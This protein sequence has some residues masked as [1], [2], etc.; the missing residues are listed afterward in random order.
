[1]AV[2]V[3]AAAADD[4]GG[5][6]QRP[7]SNAERKAKRAEAQRLGRRL[8]S[9]NLGQKGL[10]PAFLEGFR[11]ALAA[12]ELVKVGTHECRGARTAAP[13]SAPWT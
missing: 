4:S 13:L 10:T 5:G 1:M 9:V 6:H 8:C 7:L 11:L 3:A 12:N 2:A